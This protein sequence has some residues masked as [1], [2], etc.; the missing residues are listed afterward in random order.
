MP[1]TYNKG[2]L[3][4]C[5]G[6]WTD[7]A[8]TALDPTVVVFQSQTP[9][10]V[11]TSLVYGSDGAVGRSST[12]GYYCNVSLATAGTWYYRFYSTGTGQAAD[13]EKVIVTETQF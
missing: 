6:A 5:A 13:Q 4:R 10:G 7:T 8:G 2:T 12:G 1:N 11:E 3:L 9:E